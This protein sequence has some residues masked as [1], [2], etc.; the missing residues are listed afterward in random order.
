M[1]R[2]TEIKVA[3]AIA[4]VGALSGVVLGG[5]GGPSEPEIRTY[6]F[7]AEVHAASAEGEG[8]T[9]RTAYHL[10]D[11][12]DGIVGS[13]VTNVPSFRAAV[14]EWVIYWGTTASRWFPGTLE[15]MDR[16]VSVID[17]ELEIRDL[18]A[19]L[20]YLPIIESGY[21][22]DA[23]SHAAA[24]GMWQ[25]MEPTAEGLGLEVSDRIDER[26][27]PLRSTNAALTF[28]GQ[29]HERYPDSW[30][31]TLAAYNAGPGRVDQIL[32]WYGRGEEPTDALFWRIRHRFPEE[33]QQ[34]VPKL[35]GAMVVASN[36]ELHGYTE[37]GGTYRVQQQ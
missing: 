21:T 5:R 29:L 13:D 20:R 15:R 8:E 22:T 10:D 31:L 12:D 34:F 3:V 32:R 23:V 1:K 24:V 25:L 18:P 27:N 6:A 35:F 37:H 28:L 30:F 33:T 9:F 14:E 19:S 7:L 36:P 26:T 4:A 2:G 11:L 17:T 16:Y